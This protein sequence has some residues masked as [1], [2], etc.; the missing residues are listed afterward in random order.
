MLKSATSLGRSGLQDWLIQRV[1]ALILSAYFIFLLGYLFKNP[2]SNY[3]QWRS[4]FAQP[5][6]KYATL[7]ALI[8]LLVHA[9]I[10]IWTILTDYLH[11][12]VLRLALQ[13]F[14]ALLLGLYLVWGILILWG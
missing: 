1:C 10:G 6:F 9:W 14:V 4:L 11:D 7:V 12:V 8:C 13:T 5:E 3:M 2:V